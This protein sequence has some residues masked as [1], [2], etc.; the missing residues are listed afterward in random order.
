[1]E[2]RVHILHRAECGKLISEHSEPVTSDPPRMDWIT[3]RID[4]WVRKRYASFH[5]ESTSYVD[6]LIV[7]DAGR[8]Y[9]AEILRYNAIELSVDANND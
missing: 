1:M 8:G 5:S 6:V 4:K 3:E 9:V 7:T 2:Y